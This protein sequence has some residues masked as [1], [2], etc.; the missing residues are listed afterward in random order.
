M[1]DWLS[2]FI[3]VISCSLFAMKN[4]VKLNHN[5]LFSYQ[6]ANK[7]TFTTLLT[8]LPRLGWLFRFTPVATD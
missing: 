2:I 5:S 8:S 4:Y 3:T 1:S 6:E 7:R